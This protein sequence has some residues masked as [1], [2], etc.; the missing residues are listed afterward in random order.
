MPAERPRYIEAFFS[1]INWE[2]VEQR[3]NIDASSRPAAA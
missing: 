3:L 2:V 1:N